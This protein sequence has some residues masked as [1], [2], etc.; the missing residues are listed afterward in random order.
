MCLALLLVKAGFKKL[1]FMLRL[2]VLLLLTF[3][4]FQCA[5]QPIVGNGCMSQT[6]PKRVY[7]TSTGTGGTPA[8]PRYQPSA[9]GQY[10]EWTVQYDITAYP[11]YRWILVSTNGCYYRTTYNTGT[12]VTGDLGYFTGP[13]VNCPLDETIW[14]FIIPIAVVSVIILRKNTRIA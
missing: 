3:F 1:N 4:Y 14:L 5:A 10:S 2:S 8:K 7:Q 6:N 12:Y 13:A 11:C 9:T